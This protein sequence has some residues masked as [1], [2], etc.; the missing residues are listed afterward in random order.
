MNQDY[1][2]AQPVDRR[3]LI[4]FTQSNSH[5]NLEELLEGFDIERWDIAVGKMQLQIAHRN[6]AAAMVILR[7]FMQQPLI[8]PIGMQSHVSEVFSER[9][10]NMLEFAGLYFV[11]SVHETSDAMRE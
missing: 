2:N 1:Q 11:Q 6:Y 10:A 3:S 8:T 7:D 4:D 5:G 9:I